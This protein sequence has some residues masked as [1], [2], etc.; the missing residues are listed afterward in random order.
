MFC[1][2]CGAEIPDSST[3]CRECGAPV[4]GK[5]APKAPKAPK[6][7]PSL[8]DNLLNT[9]KLYVT[10]GPDEA[11]MSAAS[12]NTFEWAILLGAN[13]FFFMFAFAITSACLHFG[14]GFPLLFGLLIALI[15][16]GV[17][18]GVFFGLMAIMRKKLP[19]MGLLNLYAMTTLPLTAAAVL[20]M[21]F[22][23][24][25]H[26]LPMIFFAIALLAQFFLMFI[27]L[28]KATDN[29]VNF[30]I[31]IG[32]IAGAICI[33]FIASYWLNVA[34]VRA[35]L[36]S[37][38]SSYLD[39]EE[40]YYKADYDRREKYEKRLQRASERLTD[41]RSGLFDLYEKYTDDIL[42]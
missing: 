11:I 29:H 27:S 35:S 37:A 16:N 40:N 42:N 10:K 41:F 14:F 36:E 13:V 15:A 9:L 8:F 18:F 5:K 30:H 38:Y 4:A 31:F 17:L 2:K 33:L 23:P 34:S 28:Q 19:F 3:F 21:P 6:S 7:G 24:L 25:W 12:S 32:L 26:I 20:S 22:A 39:A 1:Q